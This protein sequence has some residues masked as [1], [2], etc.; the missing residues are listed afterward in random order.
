M[1]ELLTSLSHFFVDVKCYWEESFH[2]HGTLS[3]EGDSWKLL[4]VCQVLNI[5]FLEQYKDVED[6]FD[7]NFF[8]TVEFVTNNALKIA[9]NVRVHQST[10]ENKKAKMT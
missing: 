7:F 9:I 2:T 6:T 1:W 4:R 10:L 8:K 3:W 5:N